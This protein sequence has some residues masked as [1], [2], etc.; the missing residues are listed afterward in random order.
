MTVARRDVGMGVV[1]GVVV[2]AEWSGRIVGVVRRVW[3]SGRWGD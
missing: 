3:V 2:G 1:D